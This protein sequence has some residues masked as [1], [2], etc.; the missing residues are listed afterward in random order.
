M[1]KKVYKIQVLGSERE[2]VNPDREDIE[3]NS[4]TTKTK[5]EG[6]TLMTGNLELSK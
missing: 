4:Q 5:R 2:K 6:G 3:A 1:V